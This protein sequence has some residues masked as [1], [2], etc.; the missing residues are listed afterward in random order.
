M[1]TNED[2]RSGRQSDGDT[3]YEGD[4]DRRRHRRPP[5]NRT[6]QQV[7]P[8]RPQHVPLLGSQRPDEGPNGWDGGYGAVSSPAPMPTHVPGDFIQQPQHFYPPPTAQSAPQ[9]PHGQ[10]VYPW[11][12][13]N[14]PPPPPPPIQHLPRQQQIGGR[15]NSQP[16]QQSI[17]DSVF[18]YSG[19][20]DELHYDVPVR[21]PPMTEFSTKSSEAFGA[22]DPS[23]KQHTPPKS[24]LK[25]A[26]FG[27][28]DGME[29]ILPPARKRDHKRNNSDFVYN[30]QNSHRRTSSADLWTKREITQPTFVRDRSPLPLHPFN[31]K[32]APPAPR[33]RSGSFSAGV[34]PKPKHKRGDSMSS[35]TS[36]LS[37]KSIVSDISR[38]ALF[39]D[40]TRAGRVTFHAPSDNIR[41]VMDKD[42]KPGELYRIQGED[43]EDQYYQ[44][45]LQ[46]EEQAGFNL[47][48]GCGCECTACIRCQHKMEQILHPSLYVLR[49]EEDLYRRV[50][51]EISDSKQPCGLFF[52]GHHEDADK[53]SIL[54]AV[55]IVGAF[56]CG[57]LIMTFHYTT[58]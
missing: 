8:Q 58:Y 37:E 45:T 13:H 30:K 11:Q 47:N 51:G 22:S 55:V 31:R 29:E 56:F 4:T 53:P 35:I 48:D 26:S 41:L 1:Y 46:S 25:L 39:K 23:S 40:V 34:I 5:F 20:D 50:I 19:E 16:R 32:S 7:A 9:P 38:S 49:V 2:G 18:S 36:I 28:P 44:Y 24:I 14:V 57:M 54:I 3:A 12:H 33:S 10:P 21:G 6:S 27:E 15:S 52:C 42:L 43:E 17:F